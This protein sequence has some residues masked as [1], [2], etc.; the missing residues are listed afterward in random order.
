MLHWQVIRTP[1]LATQILG[2][3]NWKEIKINQKW[4]LKKDILHVHECVAGQIK[5]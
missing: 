1:S 5:R 3:K 4:S 2:K